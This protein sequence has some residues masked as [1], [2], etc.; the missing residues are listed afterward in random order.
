MINPVT[1]LTIADCQ[2]A[3]PEFN[4]IEQSRL[5]QISKIATT[6]L[7]DLAKQYDAFLLDA[8]GVFW[9]SSTVKVLPGSA[10]AMKY[11]VSHGKYVGIVSNS[12]Q[13]ASVEQK[14][15]EQNGLNIG[16]HFH[17]I[18][19]SGQVAKEK[20]SQ[21]DGLPF[22][23]PNHTYW[24]FGTP[25]PRFNSQQIFEGTEYHE[26]KNLADADFIYIPTPHIDGVDQTNPE[27]FRE[28][29]Q[30]VTNQGGKDIPVLSVNPDRF[31]P[32]GF[33]PRLVVRQGSI[34]QM[35]KEQQHPVFPLGKP[36]KP[37][38]ETALEQI[39]RLVGREISR[40]K[41]VMVGDSPETDVRGAHNSGLDAVLVTK[42]G[43]TAELIEKDGFTVIDS[44][45]SSDRPKF[46]LDRF[47]LANTLSQ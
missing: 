33:P 4:R 43:V 47:Q 28:Q 3:L 42:T 14:K 20:L 29:V 41:I 8:Y 26:V 2:T 46:F 18:V 23:T 36:F 24:L 44:L 34:A 7:E 22:P 5:D 30:A 10:D 9:G 15:F 32:E 1:D 16:F 21:M 25:H 45:P 19:T 35:F 37:I 27:V 38:F 6:T 11:L 13:L 12:T 39:D 31:A 17:F 40:E